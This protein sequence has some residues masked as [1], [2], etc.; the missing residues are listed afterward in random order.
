MCA[1]GELDSK[2]GVH[3]D[4]LMATVM[5][6]AMLNSDLKSATFV[7]EAV[8][9]Q[10]AVGGSHGAVLGRAH[11]P[12]HPPCM[13]EHLYRSLAHAHSQHHSEHQPPVI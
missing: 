1:E 5:L 2:C 7:M 13:W 10:Q 9:W 4:V 3:M 11:S 6:I 12:A 8:L